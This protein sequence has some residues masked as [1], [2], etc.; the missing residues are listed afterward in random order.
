MFS[1]CALFCSVSSATAFEVKNVEYI[2]STSILLLFPG[3]PIHEGI[4]EDALRA[5]SFSVDLST[6]QKI[7]FSRT[8][9]DEIKAQTWKT[10]SEMP[11]PPHA[12]V[13][14]DDDSLWS[15]SMP[16]AL[17]RNTLHYLNT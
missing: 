17:L 16:S 7:S 6:H 11:N 9:L 15:N 10:D 1:A 13:H 12:D 2:T 4:T 8:A 5:S 14:F 3:E